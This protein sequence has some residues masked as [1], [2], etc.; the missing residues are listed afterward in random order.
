VTG[1]QMD[2]AKIQDAIFAVL[3]G[4]I[5]EIPLGQVRSHLQTCALCQAAAPDLATDWVTINQALMPEPTQEFW[6]GIDD[7]ILG[8]VKAPAIPGLQAKLTDY[9]DRLVRMAASDPSLEHDIGPVVH[10]LQ[11][12]GEELDVVCH[13][14]EKALVRMSI[15][16]RKTK[17]ASRRLD[18][19]R[20]RLPSGRTY[21]IKEGGAEIP[22]Q[23][24]IEEI[25]LTIVKPDGTELRVREP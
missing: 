23:D 18:G 19:A 6:K 8:I 21:D 7:R 3:A 20:V 14:K 9:R 22:L 17:E 4:G 16:D 11:V 15:V 24:L 10:R 12:E 2:C 13:M 25:G 5:P 1:K